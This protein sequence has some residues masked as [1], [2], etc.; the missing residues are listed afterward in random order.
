MKHIYLTCLAAFGLLLSGCADGGGA[1]ATAG[2]AT[3]NQFCPVMGEAV[4]G[5]TTA[6]W[7]GK[8]IGFCC[9]PCIDEWNAMS[10]EERTAALAEAAEKKG[11]EGH[12]DHG[13][14][15]HGD[16]AE[17]E[18]GKEGDDAEHD[19]GEH[20]EEGAAAAE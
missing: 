4:D 11:G 19:H 17:H 20:E 10:D 1:T 8:T 6:E 2:A 12:G 16:H 15:D 13:D 18:D 5:E 9:P 14:H 3:A 7:N